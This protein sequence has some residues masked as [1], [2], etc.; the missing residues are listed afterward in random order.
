MASSGITKVQLGQLLPTKP[1]TRTRIPRRSSGDSA[2]KTA[3]RREIGFIIY[4]H[5]VVDNA[6]PEAEA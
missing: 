1:M 5:E 3:R 4:V 6:N 2:A